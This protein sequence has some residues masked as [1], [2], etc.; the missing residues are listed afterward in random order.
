MYVGR[1]GRGRAVA[2]DMADCIV[3]VL[4]VAPK[5]ARELKK[6]RSVKLRLLW[7]L[8]IG[9][10]GRPKQRQLGLKVWSNLCMIQVG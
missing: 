9:R 3:V 8:E 6:L 5:P 7:L 4:V 1:G 10:Q 2:L